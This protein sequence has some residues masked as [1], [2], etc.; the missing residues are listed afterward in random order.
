MSKSERRKHPRTR[1]RLRIAEIDGLGVH[2]T[3]G[4]LW[5][6]DISPGGMYLQAHVADNE[7]LGKGVSFEL[8]IPPGEGYSVSAGR[9]RGSGKVV[10]IDHAA[11][12]MAGVAVGFTSPLSLDF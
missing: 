4:D 5:T 2:D 7:L 11:E 9:I 3:A 8:S 12:R 6:C 1:L 10:R